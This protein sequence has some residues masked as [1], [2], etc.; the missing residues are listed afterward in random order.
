MIVPIVSLLVL[1]ATTNI[2]SFS[3][4]FNT[5]NDR[6]VIAFSIF[7]DSNDNNNMSSGNI[8][9]KLLS[10][11]ASNLLIGAMD[12]RSLD[13]PAKDTLYSCNAE[14]MGEALDRPWVDNDIIDLS[15]KPLVPGSV[16]WN[17]SAFAIIPLLNH[18]ELKLQGDGIPNHTTGIYPINH[19]S[20]AF[21]YDKNPNSI[22]ANNF[23]YEIPLNPEIAS[24]PN[25][26][27][28][29]TI[30]IF[31][32][33][34]AIF[35]ALD[36]DLRDAVSNELFDRCQGHPQKNGQYH[37]HHLSPC[38]LNN[39][40]SIDDYGHSTLIGIALDGF[41]IYG[42]YDANQTYISNNELDECH[43]HFGNAT[44]PIISDGGIVKE[45][46]ETYHYHAN[47]EFPYTLGCFKG[48]V[49]KLYLRQGPP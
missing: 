49:D 30:G 9:N 17:N 22:L 44:L 19:S 38:I 2:S 1:I 5:M 11:N 23:D 29:G 33:G 25:C 7:Q 20:Q 36:A 14:K 32:S 26:L 15:K 16:K 45:V 3:L 6:D 48:D 24:E 39:Q 28:M 42:P 35:N 4:G 34:A 40:N 8:G 37:Y 21:I 46:K 18:S 31:L 10:A 12:N 27:P 41:G 47:N 43:G 13:Y